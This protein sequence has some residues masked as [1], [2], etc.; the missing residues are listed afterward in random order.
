MKYTSNTIISV[1]LG[2]VILL[3]S[4]LSGCDRAPKTPKFQL[5]ETTGESL[6]AKLDENFIF[7]D[8][9]KVTHKKYLYPTRE[10]VQ[11]RFAPYWFDY[12][13]RNKL[14]Y[15]VD[16][17]NCESFSF[18]AHFASQELEGV[19][20]AV[21]VFFYMPDKNKAKGGPGHAVNI[22]VINEGERLVVD[23][24]EPQTSQFVKLSLDEIGSCSFFYF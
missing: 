14:M 4:L 24:W 13:N 22:M 12:R 1:V 9:G 7:N 18:Q 5:V 21:G 17:T 23:F 6:K 19:N 8:C 3:G 11:Q 16:A 20:V 15:D 2:A 10:W